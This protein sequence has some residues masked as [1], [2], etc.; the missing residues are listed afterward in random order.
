MVGSG[1]IT[2]R[3]KSLAL[4]EILRSETFP[5]SGLVQNFL[6]YVCEMEISEKASEITECSI[7]E[8]ALGRRN[9]FVPPE[10]AIVRNRAHM[11]RQRLKDFYD[12]EKPQSTVRVELPKGSYVPRFVA[13]P[14]K[15]TAIPLSARK[16]R[17]ASAAI[18]FLAA[19][20]LFAASF[21][22]IRA[23]RN[24]RAVDP[25][26]REAWGPLV[27]PDGNPVLVLGLPTHLIV[28]SF[29]NGSSPDNDGAGLPAPPNVAELYH[30]RAPLSASEELHLLPADS[31]SFGEAMAALAIAR[32]LESMRVSYQV[33]P[34]TAI[35]LAT[36]RSRN[37]VL[38]GD[39]TLLSTISQELQRTA[40]TVAYDASVRDFVVR[41]Q[42]GGANPLFTVAPDAS[43]PGGIHEVLGLLT[44]LPSYDTPGGDKRTLLLSCTMSAGCQAAAEFFSS[45]DT[46]KDL[47]YRFRKE[48]ITGFPRAYQVVIEGH[49]DGVLLLS[50]RYKAHRILDRTVR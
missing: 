10:D 30:R 45:P 47:H 32:T 33:L 11:L 29:P 9:D 24:P 23:T 38:I 44:V 4:E 21:L 18:G 13:V 36:L 40:L 3:Q 31:L 43:P 12:K 1:E 34:D 27:A 15:E 39:P 25:V 7:A 2:P 26:I 19:T 49:I 5:R 41:E 42:A 22:G 48:G 20:V 17:L 35:R 37:A 28:R 8:S 46:L 14:P 6:R 50:F 16:K